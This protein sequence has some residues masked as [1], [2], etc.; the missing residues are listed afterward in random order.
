[1]W[2]LHRALEGVP[3]SAAPFEW[4]IGRVCDEF[5][6]LPSA[7]LRELE[8]DPL[9]LVETIM[10]LRSYA[11]VKEAVDRRI[12]GHKV[13]LPDGPLLRLVL[14]NVERLTLEKAESESALK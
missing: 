8:T 3:G 11:N 13:D 4:T 12:A 9:R 5:H 2:G 14:K 6:C 1:M 10:M 7:A